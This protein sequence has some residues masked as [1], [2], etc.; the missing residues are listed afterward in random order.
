M[1]NTKQPFP[2]IVV[3]AMTFIA[4]IEV[5]ALRCGIDGPLVTTSVLAIAGLAGYQ[6]HT[7]TKK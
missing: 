6:H 1:N 2:T 3:S 4:I 7:T 5:V